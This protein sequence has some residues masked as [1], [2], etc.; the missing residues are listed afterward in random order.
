MLN[1]L[2]TA[3]LGGGPVGLAAAAQ[4]AQRGMPFVLFERGAQIGAS[5]LGWGHVR[6]FS[7]WEFNI[8]SAAK[9]LLLE[10]G[11]SAPPQD[12]MPT[13]KELV[14]L[15]LEPL[16]KLA[17]IRPYI[18]LE[19]TV[20]AVH[21]KGFDKM[22]TNGRELAPF[23]IEYE[24]QGELLRVEASAVIDATG[25][26]LTPNPIG[27]SGNAAD[28]ELEHQNYIT[29]GIPDSSGSS[30][31]RYAGKNI[32]VVGGG[33][34]AIQ[35]L[36]LLHELKLRVPATTIHWVLRKQSLTDVFGGG[37]NDGLPA[38]G[39]LGMRAQRYVHNGNVQVHTPF[40]IHQITK[41][42]ASSKLSLR[43]TKLGQ[44]YSIDHLDE[45]IVAT[46]SR[47]DFSFLRELRYAS[48]SVVESVPQLA[49]LID[50]NIHS[51]GTVR[52]HGEAEL[53]QPEKNFYIVGSKSYGR[54][55]T[56]LLATGYEQV[57][58]VTAALAGDEEAAREVRLHLP[59]TGVCSVPKSLP[60][61]MESG[62]SCTS[63]PKRLS[64]IP[65]AVSTPSSCCG[66][67]EEEAK[68]PSCGP[69]ACS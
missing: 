43:G 9:E 54:A 28:G 36:T 39:E 41:D 63:T 44:D 61:D 6:M 37:E 66:A 12:H 52:P 69:S 67:S 34:S 18:H 32:A 4:L 5:I 51:C 55:P 64:I 49:D 59:A 50:P 33:H 40:L 22:K 56:F 24:R 19:S 14:Q 16:S 26:W 17:Q 25:T 11:W 47:P 35:S 13:G 8:D 48:D 31:G 65:I 20:K 21:R 15:Y 7:P 53:R 38:R 42:Q 27:A 3:I 2:P 29:Y 58:S 23:V 46:G 57:R 10:A 30:I 60:A 62:S 45:V 68:A 1:L